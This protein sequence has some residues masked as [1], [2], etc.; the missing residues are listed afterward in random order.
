MCIG[1][2]QL[3]SNGVYCLCML[4]YYVRRSPN[5]PLQP[6]TRPPESNA[7]VS[8]EAV[9]AAD[10]SSIS[11]RYGLDSNILRDVLDKDELPRVDVRPE[12]LYVFIQIVNRTK[13]GRVVV[14]PMLMTV[15][16]TVFISISMTRD[17]EVQN[18][19]ARLDETD[20]TGQMLAVFAA[21]VSHYQALIQ[22]TAR[23]IQN[24]GNRLKTHEVTN[25]DFIKFVTVENNLNQY[26]LNLTGMLVVAE[27]LQTIVKAEADK[28]AVEDILLHI[29]QLVVA[30]DSHTQS[31][32]SIRRAYSTI[33]NNVLNTRIKALTILTA[34]ITVPNMFFGMY[35]MN[36][37]LPFMNE[38]W[39]Y[40]TVVII[41]IGAT[42][43]IYLLAKRLRIF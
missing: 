18:L 29:R 22:R 16:K 36:V 37:N 33:A 8:G 26:R 35:G 6:V 32:T 34:L 13:Q 17:Q 43:F 9:T 28:E 31:V 21:A 23:H 3:V 15:M 25:A 40:G 11:E 10:I 20:T 12:A 42:I 1:G 14:T 39:A 5:E 19:P 4:S 24:T 27:R 7:W 41:S 30:I 38:P 2:S